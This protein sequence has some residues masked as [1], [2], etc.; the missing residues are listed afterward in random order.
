MDEIEVV[1]DA[2]AELAEG[3]TWVAEAERLLWVDIMAGRVHTCD[4]AT[5]ADTFAEIGQPVGAAVTRTGGGLAL[6]V[7]D[8]FMLLD[9]GDGEPRLAA[10]VEADNPGTRMNNGICDAAGRFWAGTM[11]IDERP[12]AGALY[13]LDA[14]LTVTRVVEGVTISNGT[15]WSLDGRTMY[16]TDSPTHRVDAF[17]F[18]PASGAIENRRPLLTIPD[19]LGVPDG[20][21]VDAEGF[22]WIAVYGG[23]CVRRHAPDGRLERV[24]ELPVSQVTS[25][26]FGGVELDELY[27]TSAAQTLSPE[28]RE[29]EPLAGA[30]FRLRPGVHGRPEGTFAG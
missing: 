23:G 9:P 12:G 28:R 19:D 6:A 4:P 24:V 13:R 7:R 5:G 2:R 15:G 11:A 29:L 25:C 1:V 26:C 10:A 20:M 8:G 14:D 18:D 21:A 3:P 17:D 16:Y 27:I 22:L 30:V